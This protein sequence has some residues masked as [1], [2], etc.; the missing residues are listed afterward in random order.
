MVPFENLKTPSIESPLHP[1]KN[2][3]PS[4]TIPSPASFALNLSSPNIWTGKINDMLC[5]PFASQT[6]GNFWLFLDRDSEL[7]EITSSE[8]PTRDHGHLPPSKHHMNI[9]KY[10]FLNFM[11]SHIM[12]FVFYELHISISFG[13][14]I[15]GSHVFN[16]LKKNW[17]KYKRWIHNPSRNDSIKLISEFCIWF[18]SLEVKIHGYTSDHETWIT[19]KCIFYSIYQT[20]L[21]TWGIYFIHFNISKRSRLFCE[22]F[23]VFRRQRWRLI[24]VSALSLRLWV[25]RRWLVQGFARIGLATTAPKKDSEG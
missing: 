9:R 14:R 6:S 1:P 8:T 7:A 13:I 5:V 25:L 2:S 12:S 18:F 20:Q 10:Y 16:N 21:R 3:S 17:W 24:I 22:V 4:G 11:E 19:L 15:D 23:Q